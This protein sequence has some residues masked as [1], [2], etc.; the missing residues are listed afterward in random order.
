MCVNWRRF[1]VVLHESPVLHSVYVCRATCHRS[2]WKSVKTLQAADHL[3]SNHF[4]SSHVIP[5]HYPC[6][7]RKQNLVAANHVWEGL[8][9]VQENSMQRSLIQILWGKS[10]C[11]SSFATFNDTS[12]LSNFWNS[13]LCEQFPTLY[14]IHL[15]LRWSL[16]WSPQIGLPLI[17]I[18]GDSHFS[19]STAKVITAAR[20]V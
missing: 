6:V 2:A 15:S 16:S 5:C 18:F 3:S 1:I 14:Q 8:C 20:P 10:F 7:D 17:F 12:L 19:M 4:S 9:I 11:F 13:F